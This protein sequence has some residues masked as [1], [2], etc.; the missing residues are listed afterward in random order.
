MRPPNPAAA[1]LHALGAARGQN[2]SD[3]SLL[4]MLTME[5]M[6]LGPQAL[7]S[8]VMNPVLSADFSPVPAALQ[9]RKP[10][11]QGP[12]TAVAVLRGSPLVKLPHELLLGE[13]HEHHATRTQDQWGAAQL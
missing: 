13:A 4:Q 2:R 9:R 11:L 1:R 6:V 12:K 7:L 5:A 3:A 10:E 8:A